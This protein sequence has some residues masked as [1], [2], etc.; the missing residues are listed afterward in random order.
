MEKYK[1]MKLALESGQILLRAG[2]EAYRAEE[3]MNRILQSYGIDQVDTFVTPIVLIV[4][5]E[6]E[7]GPPLTLTRRIGGVSTDLERISMVNNLSRRITAEHLTLDEFRQEL[8]YIK[9][10]PA[11]TELTR[12]LI[13][14]LSAG[15]FSVMFGG[16]FKEFVAAAFIGLVMFFAVKFASKIKMNGFLQNSVGGMVAVILAQT[17]LKL[18][19]IQN[20]HAVITAD[21]ML[22]VPGVTMTNAMRDTFRGDHI[23]GL[24]RAMDAL[25]T[26]GG[27][28]FGTAVGFMILGGI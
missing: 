24:Y 14:G 13:H 8:L 1:V 10:K 6:N 27:I 20:Y 16:F 4:T 18:N 3:T 11:Y 22:L 9:T 21:L 28:A 23:S 15:A 25:L 5:G 2:S 12:F 7:D 19:F 17:V 26:A